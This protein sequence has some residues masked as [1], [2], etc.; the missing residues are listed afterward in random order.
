MQ[1]SSST[2]KRATSPNHSHLHW[3]LPTTLLL[4][5]AI[6]GILAW[7]LNAPARMSASSNSGRSQLTAVTPPAKVTTPLTDTTPGAVP[8]QSNTQAGQPG[9][10]NGTTT[11]ATATPTLLPS[12]AQ[13]TQLGVFSL[14]AGGPLPV[15]ETVLRPTNIARL[16]L[17]S[18]LI[19]VYAGSMAQNTQ[20]GIL[21]VLRENLTTGQLTLQVYQS[22]QVDGPLT[23]LS[24][25]HTKLKLTDTKG[26]G[27]FDL[28]TNQ[29]HW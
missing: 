10:Q 18:T 2:K 3:I 23:I 19:S 11:L 17:N 21:C 7:T 8:A 24:I 16:L 12:T 27:F 6:V 14:S 4:L 5:V 9:N 29:F 26:E 28:T 15:P 25:Q 13:P 20:T 22:P 1:N